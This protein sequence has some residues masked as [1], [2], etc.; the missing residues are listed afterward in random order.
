[1]DHHPDPA[2][3]EAFILEDLPEDE[4]PAFLAHVSACDDCAAKLQGEAQLELALIDVHAHARSEEKMKLRF[5]QGDERRQ[6]LAHA[7]QPP[8]A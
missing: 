6:R 8:R 2:S 5:A 1:M 4:V 7:T 3:F